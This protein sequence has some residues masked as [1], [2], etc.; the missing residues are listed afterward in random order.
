M[1]IFYNGDDE[2]GDYGTDIPMVGVKLLQ[3]PQQENGAYA[4]MY[5]CWFRGKN[6]TIW[7]LPENE[8]SAFNGLWGLAGD[9]RAMS[10]GGNG[11]GSGEPPTTLFMYPSDPT[12]S[13]GWSEC[14]ENH[15]PSERHLVMS[16]GPTIM[17]HLEPKELHFT[18]LWVREGVEY[19]CPSFAPLQQA[20]DLVQGLFDEGLITSIEEQL[21][22]SMNEKPK[23][24]LF[25]NPI[26]SNGILYLQQNS[27]SAVLQSGTLQLFDSLGQK[28]KSVALKAKRQNELQLSGLSTGVYFYR[29]EWESG[30]AEDSK[31]VVY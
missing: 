15:E 4:D 30:I 9:G 12:D 16:I 5:T 24:Q 17:Q 1:G 21:P 23:L 18:V 28:V 2:D 3:G 6:W 31:L 19:P 7:G 27:S 25:P 26:H 22:T 8:K 10:Y 13:E 20:A 14:S 11:M 29:V